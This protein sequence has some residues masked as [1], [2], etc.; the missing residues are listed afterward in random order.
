MKAADEDSLEN[1]LKDNFKLSSYESRAY[2]SLLK[3]GNQNPKQLSATAEVPLPRVYDTLES[4][5]SKGFA[6]KQDEAYSAILPRRALKGRSNQFEVQF[7]EEQKQ[8][9]VMENDLAD[10]LES[11]SSQRSEAKSSGEISILKGFNSIANK[12]TELLE[13]SSEIILIAKRAVEAR[14]V[15]IPILLGLPEGKKKRRIR[16]IVPEEADITSAEAKQASIANAEIRKSSHILFDMMIT[17]SKDV[18]IG[19]PDPL[20]EEINH[21]IAI[22]VRNSSFGS[23]TKNSVE[24]IWKSAARI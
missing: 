15:F 24:E 8:R 23:S 11:L 20:S 7:A 10:S 4:L 12:F 9:K 22:W 17:D 16:I 18:I 13:D 21:A 6:M 5:M 3:Q 2:I 14:E 1:L 19:V